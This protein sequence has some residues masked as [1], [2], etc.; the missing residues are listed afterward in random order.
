MPNPKTPQ[1]VTVKL[2]GVQ[3]NWL[4]IS[5]LLFFSEETFFEAKSLVMIDELGTG[6]GIVR[7]LIE[8][9]LNQPN[10]NHLKSS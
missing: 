6:G 10:S 8:A 2:K 1:R 7:G 3:D 9:K 5:A 4:E